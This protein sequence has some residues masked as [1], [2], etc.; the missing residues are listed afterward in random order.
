[1]V[2]HHHPGQDFRL[3]PCQNIIQCQ[4]DR[5]RDFKIIEYFF[6]VSAA[7]GYKVN[8]LGNLNSAFSQGLVSADFGLARHAMKHA[9]HFYGRMSEID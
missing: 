9:M 8:L 4:C 6:P 5:P 1:M 2:R 7:D 3:F